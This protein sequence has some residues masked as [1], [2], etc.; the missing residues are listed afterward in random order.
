MR[1]EGAAYGARGSV[2]E[3]AVPA[4]GSG[5]IGSS[6]SSTGNPGSASTVLEATPARSSGEDRV[7]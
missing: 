6:G 2:L 7:A 4:A 5:N 1:L 3:A